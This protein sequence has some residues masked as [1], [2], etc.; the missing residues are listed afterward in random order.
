MMDSEGTHVI[1][2]EHGSDRRQPTSVTQRAEGVEEGTISSASRGAPGIED[3][4]TEERDKTGGAADSRSIASEVTAMESQGIGMR[5]EALNFISPVGDG[6]TVGKW[7]LWNEEVWDFLRDELFQPGFFT[8]ALRKKVGIPPKRTAAKDT[9]LT[10]EDL[11]DGGKVTIR[12]H[13]QERKRMF[14][15]ENPHLWDEREWLP[16]RLT[17]AWATLRKE[18]YILVDRRQG[19]R[20]SY[21]PN[22]WVGYTLFRTPG[23]ER[24]GGLS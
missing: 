13:V 10:I 3:D 22:T 23:L 6:I 18:K 7:T 20:S 14:D 12:E 24:K 19:K 11:P 4:E 15:F 5:S 17:I 16:W 9:W 1:F 2:N 21:L 8:A